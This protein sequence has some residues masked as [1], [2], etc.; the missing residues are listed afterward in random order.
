MS[1]HVE[2]ETENAMR[3]TSGLSKRSELSERALWD[4]VNA[5]G[6]FL[7]AGEF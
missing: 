3:E 2:L 1:L 4:Q 7:D 5:P 6:D